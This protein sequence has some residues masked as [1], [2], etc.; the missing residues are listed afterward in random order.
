[1]TDRDVDAVRVVDPDGRGEVRGDRTALEE[2]ELAVDHAPLDILRPPEVRLDHAS[3]TGEMTDLLIGQRRQGPI[4]LRDGDLVGAAAGSRTDRDG[5]V[6]DRRL[7]DLV[8]A[9]PERI[10]DDEARHHRV[11]EAGARFDRDGPP[12]ARDRIGG[13]HDPRDRRIGHAL[14]HDGHPDQVLVDTQVP[15]VGDRPVGVRRGPASADTGDDL[16]DPDHVQE[17]VV[18]TRERRRGEVLRGG[19]R[20]HRHCHNLSE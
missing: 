19:T 18:L 10:R 15:P 3:E 12:L 9:A 8:A 6:G 13:E 11:A 5:L 16:V 4:G 14:H 1:M 20:P 7:D 17:R 2:P